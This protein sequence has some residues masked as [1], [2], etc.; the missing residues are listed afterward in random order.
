MVVAVTRGQTG[1]RYNDLL[2]TYTYTHAHTYTLSLSETS[3][4]R[5][6]PLQMGFRPG[7]SH[8]LRGYTRYKHATLFTWIIRI[9]AAGAGCLSY[10]GSTVAR[11]RIEVTRRRIYSVHCDR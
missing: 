9:L 3:I 8:Y 10:S 7:K 2:H 5:V 4:V 11:D 1:N 6:L